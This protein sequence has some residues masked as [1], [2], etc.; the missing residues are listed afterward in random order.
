MYCISY[1]IQ[2]G[3]TLYS[4]SQQY[5]ISVASIMAAN[6]LVNVYNLMVGE[7]IC[8]PISV[9]SRDILNYSTYLVVE[10]DTLGSVLEH[11]GI[12]LADLMQRN[13]LNDLYLQPGITLNVPIIDGE[14]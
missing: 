4:I 5:N 13:N 11:Y 2:K 8:I 12:N 14:E 9:P 7:V 3:D 10:G 1:V 6:P